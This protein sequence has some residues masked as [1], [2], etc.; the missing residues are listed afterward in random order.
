MRITVVYD[1]EVRRVGLSKGHGFSALV[2]N[3][4]VPPLLFDTGADGPTLLH[5]MKELNIDPRLPDLARATWDC[6]RLSRVS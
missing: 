5:N 2:E 3:E 1:N 6:R 4:E